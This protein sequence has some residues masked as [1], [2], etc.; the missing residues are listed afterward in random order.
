MKKLNPMSDEAMA[1]FKA[2]N[3]EA[4]SENEL[5]HS[6]I[7]WKEA[8]LKRLMATEVPYSYYGHRNVWM[9]M[10]KAEWCNLKWVLKDVRNLIGDYIGYKTGFSPSGVDVP[11][12]TDNDGHIMDHKGPAVIIGSG[13]S[14]DDAAEWLPEWEG[15]IFCSM[16]NQ[17]STLHH[18]GAD[19][20]HILCFDSQLFVNEIENLPIKRH[21]SKV[22]TH[23]GI[24]PRSNNAIKAQRYW[25]KVFAPSVSFYSDILAQAYNFIH[26]T[27]YPYACAIA[28]QTAFAHYMGYAPLIYVGCDFAFRP[29]QSRFTEWTRERKGLRW[30][31]S[32]NKPSTPVEASQNVPLVKTSTGRLTHNIHLHYAI[33][34]AALIWLGGQ[35]VYDM[36]DGYLTGL[37]DKITPDDLR[38]IQ[39]APKAWIKSR[40]KIR[41]FLEP[42][43]ATKGTFHVPMLEAFKL[44]E[45]RDW[46]K[47]LPVAL[48]LMQKD[49]PNIDI[50]AFMEHAE[51]LIEKAKEIDYGEHN[52]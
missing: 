42:W 49:D 37:F 19:P 40:Q 47:E 33:A 39:L 14:L 35:T 10:N 51:G 7:P 13:P 34:V 6:S 36:S 46:R 44:I 20:T 24:H 1:K 18:Y 45:T 43:L 26:P 8:T 25:Y 9:D 27:L 32:V 11:A 52:E 29:Q 22:I 12:G 2:G 38:D 31:W 23:P 50:D 5:D 30:K 28:G 17:V 16:G 15:A 41:D 21:Y 4:I 3:F 48:G